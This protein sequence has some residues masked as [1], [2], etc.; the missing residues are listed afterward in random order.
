MDR[1]KELEKLNKAYRSAKSAYEKA[2]AEQM[3]Y[4]KTNG[5]DKVEAEDG[6]C[7]VK[8]IHQEPVNMPAYT[9]KS[10][11]YLRLF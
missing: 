6:T 2:M 9:K 10:Y 4:M 3:E 1:V 11:D 8:L 5:L 7:Y